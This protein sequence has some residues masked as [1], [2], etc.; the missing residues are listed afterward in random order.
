MY[1]MRKVEIYMYV[2]K[3]ENRIE[4]IILVDLPL[5]DK[6]HTI[7]VL[8]KSSLPT[9]SLE[10]ILDLDSSTRTIVTRPARNRADYSR[11]KTG[12]FQKRLLPAAS[13]DESSLILTAATPLK[14]FAKV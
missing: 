6:E 8:E 1:M 4:T 3:Y 14:A 7:S 12:V 9:R 13:R 5:S 11:Y 2:C 10:L